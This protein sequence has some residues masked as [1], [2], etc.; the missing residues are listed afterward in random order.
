MTDREKLLA[1][2]AEFGITPAPNNEPD[3]EF[4]VDLQAQ[5]GGVAGYDRFRCVF[6]FN[7]DGAFDGVG[8]WE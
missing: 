6:T 7:E 1:L 8:V 2:L 5:V 4:D 3:T